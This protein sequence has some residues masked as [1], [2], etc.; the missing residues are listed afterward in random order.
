MKFRE[1]FGEFPPRYMDKIE[2]AT[3]LSP[4]V[5]LWI[6]SRNIAFHKARAKQN[7][8]VEHLVNTDEQ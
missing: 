3:E 6:R 4:G 7:A 8:T 2:P 1:K 5:A